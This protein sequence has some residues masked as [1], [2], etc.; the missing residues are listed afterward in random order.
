MSDIG[1][2]PDEP[3]GSTAPCPRCGT[4]MVPIAWG[5]PDADLFE[6]GDRGEVFI[7][8]CCI[9]TW[10]VPQWFCRRCDRHVHLPEVS[11]TGL[12]PAVG[13]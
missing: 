4:D 12:G 11:A 3:W 1:G 7:G 8:G 5:F 2:L 10:E 13:G 9:P 6:A